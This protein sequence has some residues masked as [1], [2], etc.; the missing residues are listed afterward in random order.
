MSYI[1]IGIRKHDNGTLYHEENFEEAIR[2]VNFAYNKTSLP[3]NIQNLFQD[4]KLINLTS[5]VSIL[6]NM[7]K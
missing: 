7:Y 4:E 1:I 6:L 3:I 5:N 2:S